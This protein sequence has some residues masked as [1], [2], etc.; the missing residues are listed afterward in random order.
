MP[1]K[2]YYVVL[3]VSRTESAEQIR[4]AFRALARRYHPDRAGPRATAQFQ[5][6]AEAYEV[7]SDADRRAAY[8]RGLE[9]VGDSSP[10]HRRP[11]VRTPSAGI[12]PEPL[13]PRPH[14]PMQ[15]A[16]VGGPMNDWL[17]ERFAEGFGADDGRRQLKP[18]PLV[19]K[20]SPREAARG[21]LLDL[22][23]PVYYPCRTC[24]GSGWRIGRRCRMCEGHGLRE[25]LEP[26]TVV[27]PPMVAHG[28]IMDVPLR[29]LGLSGMFLELHIVVD[30][31]PTS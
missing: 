12:E 21:G 11:P 14:R 7:L 19:V 2:D 3:G 28:A 9:H 15:H 13:I 24:R 1:V 18:L 30:G 26:V 31:R 29:G 10:V 17:R 23:V 8:D 4:S 20:L 27:V 16:Q 25:H 5:Q 22:A 6:I